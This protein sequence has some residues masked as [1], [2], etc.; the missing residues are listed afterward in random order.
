MDIL[1]LMDKVDPDIILI[2]LTGFFVGLIGWLN[3]DIKKLKII[4]A[5]ILTSMFTCYFVYSLL[6]LTNLPHTTNTGIS[7]FVT[8][9]GI[10]KS[11]EYANKIIELFKKAKDK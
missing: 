11:I 10:D 1:R 3:S 7:A 5:N 6:I 8:L 4:I 2:L 9:L